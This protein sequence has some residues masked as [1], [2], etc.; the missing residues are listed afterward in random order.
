MSVEIKKYDF[1]TC[2]NNFNNIIIPDDR[3]ISLKRYTHNGE[4]DNK[5]IRAISW[6][7]FLN[8]ISINENP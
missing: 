4:L 2:V 3:K 7:F 8:I 5:K 1:Q 6:K